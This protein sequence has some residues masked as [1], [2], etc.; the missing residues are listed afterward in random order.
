[1]D[2]NK[3]EAT[4]DE[5]FDS[6]ESGHFARALASGDQLVA[7]NP[8]DARGWALRAGA[9]FDGDNPREALEN[10]TRAVFIDPDF[11][12]AQ[13]LLALSAWRMDHLDTAQRA[14]QAVVALSEHDAVHLAEYAWFMA[15]ARAFGAAERAA[16]EAIKADIDSAV[17][18]AALALAQWKHG[19]RK[20]A[21]RS[22]EQALRCDSNSPRALETMAHFLAEDGETD[23]AEAIADLI[24]GESG[25]EEFADTIRRRARQ[26]GAFNTLLAREEVQR[27]LAEPPSPPWWQSRV[28]YFVGVVLLVLPI[29][30][31]AGRSAVA[32]GVMVATIV[33]FR[34]WLLE[35]I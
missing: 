27:R 12:W 24:G 9:L 11:M 33:A 10:A 26:R 19:R 17:A 3:F 7:A 18:W 13:H 35:D 22:V 21:R 20:D 8:E 25:D 2:P 1:M 28:L 34:M 4:F 32:F 6:L 23:K 15:H 31:L 29:L 30:S 16:S 14:F 5:G